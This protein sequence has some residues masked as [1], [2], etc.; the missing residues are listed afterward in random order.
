MASD[1]A[2]SLSARSL[3]DAHGTLLRR[4][5]PRFPA[6]HPYT[7]YFLSRAVDHLSLATCPQYPVDTY[8]R[9]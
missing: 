9:L 4:T 5:S 2:G 1:F 7:T 3:D 8:A 6:H